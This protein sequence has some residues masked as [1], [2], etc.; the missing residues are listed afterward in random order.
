MKRLG[1]NARMTLT[2]N[3]VILLALT[4]LISLQVRQSYRSTREQAF[5]N[6]QETACRY[7]NQ[8]DASL[9]AAMLTARTLAQT[10]EGMKL[11]RVDDRGLYNSLLSQVL[12]ANTNFLAVWSSFVG[13][14]GFDLYAQR[15][16]KYAPPLAPMNAPLVYVPFVLSNKVYQPQ[17]EVFWEFQSGLPVAQYSVYVNGAATAAASMVTNVWL[18]TAANGLTA[19]SSNYFQVTYSTTSGSQAPL[20]PATGATTWSGISYYGIPVEWMEEYWGDAWPSATAPLSPG[21]PTPLQAFLSGANPLEPATWLTTALV[22]SAEGFYL[23]WN[24]QPGH[25]YQVESSSDLHTWVSVGSPRFAPGNL[26]SILV[27]STAPA[28]YRILCLH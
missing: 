28:Y 9:D 8:V 10:L 15:Y 25:T 24:P 22:N 3:G 1:L 17:V 4:C 20:S 6:G 13:S 11:A 2:I 27:G 5:Q 21:G 16:A 19:N 23:T 26:D 12:R 14:T 7:A 18:M